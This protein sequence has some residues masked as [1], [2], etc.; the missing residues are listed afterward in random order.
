MLALAAVPLLPCLRAHAVPAAPTAPAA[1]LDLNRFLHLSQV[2]TGRPTLDPIIGGRALAALSAED[3]RFSAQAGALLQAMTAASFTD[4]RTFKAFIAGHEAL[5]PV[6]L[7]II[8]AWYLGYTGTPAGNSD[9]DDARFVSYAGALMYQPT[10]DATV[11]PTYSRGAT[12]YWAAPPAT[13][14]TD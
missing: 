5:R 12:D 14:A 9:Q 4:M 6:A 8:S 10:I 3:R 2:L 1:A 13:L 7:K 11:V